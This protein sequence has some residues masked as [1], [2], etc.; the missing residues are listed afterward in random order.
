MNI[1]GSIQQKNGKY[2]MVFNIPTQGGKSKQKWKTTGLPIRGNKKAAE[3]L[4]R[5]T[6]EE[7][8]EDTTLGYSI[9]VARYFK[10]WLKEI[11]DT[12]RPNTLRGYKNNMENHII[13]YFSANKMLLQD[14]KPYHLDN[15]YSQKLGSKHLSNSGKSLSGSTI[16]HHHQNISK[17]LN[18]ALRKGYISTNPAVLAKIPKAEKYQASFLEPEEM[19]LLMSLIEGSEIE[20]PVK[21]CA[22][23]GLRRS[24]VLG[25]RWE[26]IDLDKNVLLVIET[27][28]QHIGCDY[29]DDTKTFYSKR[30]LPITDS[31]KTLLLKHKKLQ[32]ERFKAMGNYYEESDY[33]CTFSNGKRISPNYLSKKF[34]QIILKSS[35]P[36]IRLHDLRHSVASNLLN[37]GFSV[38]EVRDWMGHAN[39]STTLD[40]YAHAMKNSKQKLANKLDEIF[41]M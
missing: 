17:A 10:E 22:M 15:Y 2:H 21:L 13:P 20:L 1:T 33:L 30:F 23:Y 18:D 27:F 31:I 16:K 12:V 11:E 25:L 26:N 37:S 4:L 19:V 7:M 28:Q 14:L 29:I 3:R 39:A 9:Q 24:E 38:V 35:L 32:N 40:I 5:E 41:E 34:H 6:L 8:N 36:T